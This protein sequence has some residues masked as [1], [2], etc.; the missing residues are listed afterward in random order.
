MSLSPS[1]IGLRTMYGKDFIVLQVCC[2][3]F[4]GQKVKGLGILGLK[5]YKCTFLLYVSEFPV[6]F[7]PDLD[8]NLC[9]CVVIK[10]NWQIFVILCPTTGSL[11]KLQPRRYFKMWEGIRTKKINK[12]NKNK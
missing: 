2:C 4:L 7:G 11:Q 1:L 12:I 9:K 8:G 5:H 10:Q 3:Y 6:T